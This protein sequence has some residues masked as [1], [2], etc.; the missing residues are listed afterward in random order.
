MEKLVPELIE[1]RPNTYV[2]SKALAEHVVC[3]EMA[4]LTVAIARPAIVGPTVAEPVK[5]WV[6]SLHGPAGLSILAGLG[7]IQTIDWES[8]V[9]PDAIAVDH[10]CNALIASAW[11]MAQFNPNQHKIFNLTSSNL[12]PMSA[13]QFMTHARKASLKY[14]SLYMVRPL[15]HPPKGRIN[16]TI[17][18]LQQ[19]FYHILFAYF[20]DFILGIVGREKM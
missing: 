20:I 14:P 12:R 2:Y 17:Y 11:H 18:K 4:G 5:G 19:F 1:G 10:L 16:P 7:I 6:D 8:E 15:M 3:S 13:Y 9:K